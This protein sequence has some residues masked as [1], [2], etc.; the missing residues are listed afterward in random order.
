MSEQNLNQDIRPSLVE[1]TDNS[2]K[3]QDT[4][5]LE[6]GVAV[7]TATDGNEDVDDLPESEF[8]SNFARP[9]E[10]QR[11]YDNYEHAVRAAAEHVQT[12][13]VMEPGGQPPAGQHQ[14]PNNTMQKC[15]RP[16]LG[17]VGLGIRVGSNVYDFIRIDFQ[18]YDPKK[19]NVNWGIH[20]NSQV[21]AKGGNNINYEVAKFAGFITRGG[22]ND[23]A[24]WERRFNNYKF[25]LQQPEVTHGIVWEAWKNGQQPR[26]PDNPHLEA[27][28]A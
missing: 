10:I 5:H 13:R 12:G 25:I 4:Q 14:A 21:L 20:F 24:F 19:P 15:T 16:Q 9:P 3:G 18:P 1:T 28:E 7:D 27:S 11:V 2:R 17:L 8:A 26:H 23:N 6:S 22:N